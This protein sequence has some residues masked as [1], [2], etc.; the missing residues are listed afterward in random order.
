MS[1]FLFQELTYAQQDQN[2]ARLEG[3]IRVLEEERVTW[4]EVCMTLTDRPEVITPRNSHE[5]NA[6]AYLKSPS[7]SA[8]ADSISFEA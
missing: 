5:I 7:Y 6:P 3:V 4:Q 2:V 8:E 1:L